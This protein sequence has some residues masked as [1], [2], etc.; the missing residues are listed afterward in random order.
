[1]WGLGSR[2]SC[3]RICI[4]MWSCVCVCVQKYMYVHPYI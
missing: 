1:L 3:L 4:Y 2:G